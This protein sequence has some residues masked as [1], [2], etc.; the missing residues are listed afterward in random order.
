MKSRRDFQGL[1]ATY[2]KSDPTPPPAPNPLQPCC[3]LG[4]ADYSVHMPPPL[5]CRHFPLPH[6]RARAGPEF[7]KRR[8]IW[9]KKRSSRFLAPV[10]TGPSVV[11]TAPC[12]MAQWQSHPSGADG[13][14]GIHS[15]VVQFSLVSWPL[16]C[17][18]S[19]CLSDSFPL[20]CCRIRRY[21]SS[22]KPDW[23]FT[24]DQNT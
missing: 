19:N 15:S 20:S 16:G 24:C 2:E 1:C 14:F 8:L 6:T 5:V 18:S 17:W 11:P 3:L 23:P 9:V 10:R 4:P 22:I 7:I 21:L 12:A 13:L